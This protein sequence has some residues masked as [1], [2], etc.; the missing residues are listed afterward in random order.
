MRAKYP[1]NPQKIACSYTYVRRIFQNTNSNYNENHGQRKR[2][3][4]HI[5]SVSITPVIII[6][7]LQ[8][9]LQ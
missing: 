6:S 2:Y 7:V 1:L 4:Q 5:A 8:I 9:E 3:Q